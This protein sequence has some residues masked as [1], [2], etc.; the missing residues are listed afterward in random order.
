MD[1]RSQAGLDLG[2]LG[3]SV[4]AGALGWRKSTIPGQEGVEY[5]E[6]RA[7]MGGARGTEWMGVPVRSRHGQEVRRKPKE[8]H[9]LQTQGGKL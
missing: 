9:M 3:G 2:V 8:N 5:E 6:E 4:I 1:E 7:E